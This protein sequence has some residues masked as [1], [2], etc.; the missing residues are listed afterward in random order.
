M[1]IIHVDDEW[2]STENFKLTLKKIYPEYNLE[3]F[4]DPEDAVEFAQDHK[5]DI[6]F[7]DIEMYGM[8]GIELADELKKVQKQLQ[9]IFVTAYNNYAME[10]F[11][12]KAQGYLLKP[13]DEDM[14]KQA[15]DEVLVNIQPPVPH[16]YF[17]TMPRFDMLVDGE[18]VTFGGRKI[19]ELMA[20]FVECGGSVMNP[21]QILTNVWED[22]EIDATAT[23]RLRTTVKRLNDVLK[24]YGVQ[25]LLKSSG[26]N[27]YIEVSQ[28][29]S[30]YKRLMAGDQELLNAYD[31]RYMEDYAWAEYTEAAIT[32][33][34]EK[35]KANK[36]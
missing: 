24:K 7:L 2:I 34:V 10:A 5:I 35:M 3:S 17:R 12:V 23:A 21:R 28:Y 27:R 14:L 33:F 8:N 22:N 31:G 36:K 26:S 6:A 1:Q 16:I 4:N 19:K 13:Y 20:Y 15:L 18:L 25:D 30:D 11:K 32:T 9:V 29:D